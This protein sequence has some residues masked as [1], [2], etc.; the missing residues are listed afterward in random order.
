MAIT[1]GQGYDRFTRFP[2]SGHRLGLLY[3]MVSI[4]TS[5]EKAGNE[6][7]LQPLILPSIGHAGDRGDAQL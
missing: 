4:P 1:R 7:K 6:L 2:V 5:G 3:I